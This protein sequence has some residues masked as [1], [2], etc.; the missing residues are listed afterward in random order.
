MKLSPSLLSAD[1]SRLFEEAMS[2]AALADRFH[3]D[4]MDGHFVPNLTFGPPVVNAL[5]PRLS[6][7]FD[8][9]LMIDRPAMYAPQFDVRP[10][11]TITFHLESADSADSAM[12]A[13]RATGCRIGLSLRPG[14]PLARL[15]PY[16]DV[17]D[18]VLL[19]TVE[20]GFG[21]QG[22]LPGS[23]ERIADLKRRIAS[24]AVEI[25]V[26]GGVHEGNAGAIVAHGA[27]VLVAGSAVF[28]AAD[29]LAAMRA[30]REAAGERN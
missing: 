14:V 25:A 9:H 3:W 8:I 22:F 15:E 20:P 1:F 23:L 30:I 17:I 13:I 7:P 12:A 6:Q 19:M 21:G 28:G 26:D 11:D 2:V 10:H 29:R 16:L 18:H 27:D 24:R 4:V 5:R